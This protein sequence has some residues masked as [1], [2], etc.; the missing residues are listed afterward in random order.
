MLVLSFTGK[1][2]K[3]IHY[4]WTWDIWRCVVTDKW[5][6]EQVRLNSLDNLTCTYAARAWWAH[7]RWWEEWHIYKTQTFIKR[8]KMDDWIGVLA[9]KKVHFTFSSLA[10]TFS[11]NEKNYMVSNSISHMQRNRVPCCC[12]TQFYL[13]ISHPLTFLTR[14]WCSSDWLK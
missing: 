12:H 14:A 8:S 3:Q 6:Y 5:E 10:E 4:K 7:Y 2:R 9:L 13:I 11:E 1:D